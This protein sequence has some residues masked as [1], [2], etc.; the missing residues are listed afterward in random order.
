[1]KTPTICWRALGSRVTSLA[2]A[3][4][5]LLSLVPALTPQAQAASW[6]D[7]YLEKV[8]EWGVMRG[9][10][11]GN[12]NPNNYI[13]RAEFVTMTNRAY[14][15]TATGK[16]PY[17]DATVDDWFYED[18]GIAYNT[19]Y[20]A[21]TSSNT[22][23]P[24]ANLTREQAATLLGRNMML[25][26]GTGETLT[27]SDSRELSSWS[28]HMVES[29]AKE[30][31]VSGYPDGTFKPQGYVTRG[32]VASMLV[33][34]V[35]QPIQDS[36]VHSL[37]TVNSNLTITVPGVTLRDTTV[38]G[39]LYISAGVGLGNVVLENVDVQGKIVV[40][41]AGESEEGE[42]SVVL[43]N[44]EADELVMDSLSDQFVTLRAEGDTDIKNVYARTQVYLED[45]TDDGKGLQNILLKAE[46]NTPFQLAGNIKNVRLETSGSTLTIAQGV[47][48][49]LTVDEAALKT[50]VD[51]KNKAIVTTVNLDAGTNL[52]GGGDISHL[53]VNAPG[54]TV[55]MLPDTITIRPGVTADIAGVNMDSVAAVEASENP[56]LLAG[57]PKEQNVAPTSAEVVFKTNKTGT[58]YWGLT[59]LADGSLDED[60]LIKPP[61]Y[62]GKIL[63]SG[64]IS[65]TAS[66][67]EVLAKL[68]G[69]VSDGSYYVS[70]VLV[71]SRGMRSP[72]K[73]V[74]FT[75]PDNTVP[76]F[77]QSEMTL[78]TNEDAQVTVMANKTCQLYWAVLPKGSTAP[79]AADFKAGA[80]EGNLGSG[81][82]QVTKNS[83]HPFY[84]NSPSGNLVEE[85]T[86]DLYLWLTD[87]DGAKSSSVKKLTFSTVDKT[88]PVV[89]AIYQSNQAAKTITISFDIN[90]AATLYWGVV[91]A[92]DS[93]IR[94]VG[95][96]T[97]PPELN[98][99]AAKLQVEAGT[100]AIKK[101]NKSISKSG[102]TATFTISG[103][104]EQ[105]AYDLYYVAKDKAGN[106]SERVQVLQ[107]IKTQDTKAPTVEQ[108]F[109]EFTSNGNPLPETDVELHFSEE[110]WGYYTESNSKKYDDFLSLYNDVVNAE[111]DKP[112]KKRTLAAALRKYITL[113]T[114]DA[115]TGKAEKAVDSADVRETSQKDTWVINYEEAIVTR[116]EGKTTITFPTDRQNADNGAL[117]LASGGT[118][119]FV[120]NS[121]SDTSG[122]AMPKTEL[123]RFTTVFA[124]V[125]LGGVSQTVQILKDDLAEQS[126]SNLDNG[127][128]RVDMSFTMFPESTERVPEGTKW[129]MLL[130]TD[131]SMEYTLYSRE[132]GETKWTNET[133]KL[134][135]GVVPVTI[136]GTSGSKVY[137]SLTR[138]IRGEQ[139][140]RELKQFNKNIEFAV[141]VNKIEDDPDYV[142]WNKNVTMGVNVVAGITNAVQQAGINTLGNE[143]DYQRALNT[144]AVSIGVDDPFE[145]TIPFTDKEA[146][147]LVGTYPQFEVGDV[148]A[149]M[150]VSL[151][152]PGTVYYVAVPISG[153]GKLDST[154]H[155]T[156]DTYSGELLPANNGGR[157]D[158]GTIP[159]AG[160]DKNVD[161]ARLEVEQPT[162]NQIINPTGLVNSKKGNTSNI[163]KPL[164][165]SQVY[166]ISLEDLTPKTT[167][168]V[169]LVIQ[170]VSPV[171]SET[172]CYQFTT[173]E[174]QRPVL[175]MDI[176]NPNVHIKVD[177][178]SDVNY[179]LAVTGQE[180]QSFRNDFS[181]YVDAETKNILQSD[182]NKKKYLESKYSV[183]NAMSE[184][185]TVDGKHGTVFDFYATEDAKSTFA[186]LIQTSRVTGSNI[187]MVGSGTIKINGTL[188]V[189]C[190]KDMELDTY[191]TMIA[192]A[193][194]HTGSGYAFRAIWPVFNRDSVPPYI[195]SSNFVTN[196]VYTDGNGTTKVNGELTVVFSEALYV[197][198]TGSTD[199]N[200]LPLDD[201]GANDVNH[202]DGSTFTPVGD[203]L[204]LN[205]GITY[206]SSGERHDE[207]CTVMTFTVQNAPLNS[208]VTFV[209]TYTLCDKNG[210]T[211][212]EAL[213]LTLKSRTVG[214]GDQATT[215]YYFDYPDSWSAANNTAN[216]KK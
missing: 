172:L 144:G 108:E 176:N 121:I 14:G 157:V 120:L 10:I 169:F 83:T 153:A 165:A 85:Q 20:F 58:L 212:K 59:A 23:A 207:G 163:Q 62:S 40:A 31:F 60:E 53:N 149:K 183:L 164:S 116:E 187:K 82:M 204:R 91:L 137:A 16:N 155:A 9:D 30:G 92:G 186:S 112:E 100:Y 182:T 122:N 37:G 117:N 13:T 175:D 3:L 52:I 129:D 195:Q 132:E 216:T 114:V 167:Y 168:L 201:C 46:D 203:Y 63:K 70:A 118:Y 2:L 77:M 215:E 135:N 54:S 98:E 11:Q 188:T 123:P 103:L 49:T 79:K 25:Q 87:F 154:G 136:S 197:K 214:T 5:L 74:A 105:T 50:T 106:Y 12:L 27:F 115:T 44:V 101:G 161:N 61:A 96:E 196:R 69:L 51:I 147:S 158:L 151:N 48:K 127:V 213:T 84:V 22:A 177:K 18:L 171:Y 75:T 6:M 141:H 170:G 184:M 26:E 57:Y 76:K 133:A 24:L 64:S 1:M 78:V 162:K 126:D 199:Q 130:W 38:N 81:N 189:N 86:Y 148:A 45:M 71:D 68:S 210:N 185:I 134:K 80:I 178:T 102:S 159:L 139:V 67:T 193:K 93:L 28:R 156:G 104:T 47:T 7:P 181:T 200:Y 166:T 73:V 39:N 66:N 119:Y 35:G 205:S 29:A 94:P 113:Y 192:V 211:Q 191:H 128:V 138:L 173:L 21:G 202:T 180:D 43:R 55:A 179:I 110:V 152:R 131:S 142:A 99:L 41:G 89:T 72:V 33:R 8:Q 145:V 109:T 143:V 97:K 107:G 36:G 206:T 125:T 88:P 17:K 208:Q 65:M 194:A 56:R 174:A 4:A 150:Q 209:P 146:P 19:G 34:A 198:K 124:K 190:E 95:N 140:F 111:L 160:D 42:H 32:E 90:E 15:Y